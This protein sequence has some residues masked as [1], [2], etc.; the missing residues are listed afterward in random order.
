MDNPAPEMYTAEE[1][2]A[3]EKHIQENFGSFRNIFHEIYS[4]DIHV[5]ICV[6]PPTDES[7]HYTLVT[8]GMGAHRMNVP[9]ELAQYHLERAELAICL[10]ADWDI[11]SQDEKNYWPLRL[12]KMLARMPVSE[13]TWLGWGHTIDYGQ[14]FAENTE[15]SSV[16]LLDP[17]ASEDAAVLTLPNGENVNF[18]QLIPL[19]KEEQDY[20]LKNG[21]N[22][23][24][25]QFY[26]L[27]PVVDI[28]RECVIG[29]VDMTAMDS[30]SNH[31]EK[32]PS[33][34]LAI[35][36]KLAG[37]NHIA[38]YLRWCIEHGL[39]SE[40]FSSRYGDIIQQTLTGGAKAPLREFLMSEY[41][42]YLYR[43]IFNEE[44]QRFAA[45]YY[46]FSNEDHC[47][48][49]SVDDFALEYFGE[50]R[51]NCAEFKDEAYLFIP[52]DENYY[53]GIKKHIDR[54]YAAFKAET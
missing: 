27:S 41:K 14:S 49:C 47:Y 6:V 10:P 35:D 32:I 54:H 9:E 13:D 52:Y 5:D 24:L 31:S 50:E 18:Y 36:D 40:E 12:L 3:V 23:L 15:L 16:L 8:M 2:E 44:G 53:N 11:Q 1:M 4:P 17:A 29:D 25:K 34:Q 19:Y 42:G 21:T 51:Y 43:E 22:E 45:F 38:A 33:K 28:T 20:K 37:G 39:M 30:F 7:G 46:D 26:D 48:P